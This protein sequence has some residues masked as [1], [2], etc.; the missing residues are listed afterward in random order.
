MPTQQ[1]GR[2][3]LEACAHAGQDHRD[4]AIARAAVRYVRARHLPKILSAKP[5]EIADLSLQGRR[6]LIARLLRLARNSARAGAS[7]HW[8]YDPNRH[9]AILGALQAERSAVAALAGGGDTETD[10]PLRAPSDIS[11]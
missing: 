3:R 11:T 8:S 4:G 9:V 6:K 7:G 1:P 5:D 10:G 2:Q